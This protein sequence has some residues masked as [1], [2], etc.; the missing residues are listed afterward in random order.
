MS[1]FR[2]VPCVSLIGALAWLMI[3]AASQAADY[4]IVVSQATQSDSDRSKVVDELVGKHQAD[5]VAHDRQVS[6]TLRALQRT[7]P[8]YVCVVA[9]SAEAGPY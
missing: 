5:V 6:E 4:V 9:T 1:W 8:R 2:K 3:G 7:F